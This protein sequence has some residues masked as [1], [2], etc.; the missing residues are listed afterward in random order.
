MYSLVLML[1]SWVR[2]AVLA[3]G[4]VTTVSA[5]TDATGGRTD[6]T[7]LIFMMVTDIQMLLGLMLYLALSPFTAAALH[8]FGAAMRNPTLR[9]WA[10]EHSA[11]MLLAVILVHVGRVLARTARTPESKRT[12]RIVCFGLAV[13][14]MTVATP[15]P[16]MA[17]GR[18]LFRV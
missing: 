1:H 8:D 11:T 5:F 3:L 16:G 12:R 7:S 2:W 6:R 14:L 4:I 15:W 13:V 18:P 17:N 10:V 9:F